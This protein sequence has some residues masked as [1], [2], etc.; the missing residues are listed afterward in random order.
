MENFLPVLQLLH[1]DGSGEQH[2]LGA[3][4]EGLGCQGVGAST[5]WSVGSVCSIRRRLTVTSCVCFV[6]V[7]HGDDVPGILFLGLEPRGSDTS[8]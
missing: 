1:K 8:V 7:L 5:H 4:G 6:F 3:L 2:N